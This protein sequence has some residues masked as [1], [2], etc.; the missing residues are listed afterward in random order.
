MYLTYGFLRQDCWT[1]QHWVKNFGEY[2][3][4]GIELG[5]EI[6]QIPFPT[7]AFIPTPRVLKPLKSDLP[8]YCSSHKD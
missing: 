7:N 8:Y 1:I 2:P 6:A 4:M 3:G 5:E